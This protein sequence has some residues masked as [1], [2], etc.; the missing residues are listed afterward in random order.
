M[1]VGETLRRLVGKRL[2]AD[3]DTL[4][5]ARSLLPYQTGVRVQDACLLTSLSLPQA[6]DGWS[7]GDSWVVVQVDLTNAFNSIDPEK[8][9]QRVKERGP[10]LLPFAMSCYGRHSSLYCNSQVLESQQGANKGTLWAPSCLPLLGT[11]WS[12]LQ[13]WVLTGARGTSMTVTS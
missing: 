7:H 4:E 9:L 10:H 12:R 13:G 5:A 6:V 2:M 3:M 11:R 1:A 8:I